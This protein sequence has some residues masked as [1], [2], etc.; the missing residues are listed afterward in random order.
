MICG[1]TT[2]SMERDSFQ[3]TKL[4]LETEEQGYKCAVHGVIGFRPSAGIFE[5]SQIR[6]IS[7]ELFEYRTVP[8]ACASRESFAHGSHT[9]FSETYSNILRLHC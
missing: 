8:T 9:E 5:D 1:G 7:W 3:S 2:P 4:E 6:N